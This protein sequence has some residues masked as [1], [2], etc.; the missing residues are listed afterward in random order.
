M[1][2]F[3]SI[4]FL[5]PLF[6][7]AQVTRFL[8]EMDTT[9]APNPYLESNSTDWDAFLSSAAVSQPFDIYAPDNELLSATV[10]HVI[11]RFRKK[12]RRPLFIYERSLDKVAANSFEI[13]SRSSFKSER[14]KVA[15]LN[16]VVDVAGRKMGA[17]PGIIDLYASLPST[18]EYR[19]GGWWYKGDDATTEHHLFYGKEDYYEKD[20]TR[21]PRPLQFYT[22]LAFAEKLVRDWARKNGAYFRSKTL[23]FMTCRVATEPTSHNR[24]GNLPYARAIVIFGAYRTDRSQVLD[25]A[26]ED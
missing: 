18:I 21:V 15:K 23:E 14:E 10:F 25:E 9:V 26:T 4:A 1:K 17:L 12:K 16:K 5:V 11:N 19:G 8:R 2:L 20:S 3:L 6:A 24:R 13:L 7:Q 22:Y